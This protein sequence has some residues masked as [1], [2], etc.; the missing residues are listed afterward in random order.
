[1]CLGRM[2]SAHR[3]RSLEHRT[4]LRSGRSSEGKELLCWGENGIPERG[5]AEPAKGGTKKR[6]I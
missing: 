5:Q 6:R 4:A 2:H 3:T 1:M